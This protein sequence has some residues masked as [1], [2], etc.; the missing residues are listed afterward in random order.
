[1]ASWRLDHVRLSG[2]G[3]LEFDLVLWAHFCSLGLCSSPSAGPWTVE[4]IDGDGFPVQKVEL[5]VESHLAVPRRE[6]YCPREV[7]ER[8]RDALKGCSFHPIP[9]IPILLV[10]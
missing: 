3:I 1:M 7:P 2:T 6:P 5:P 4:A 9:A 8:V 10:I